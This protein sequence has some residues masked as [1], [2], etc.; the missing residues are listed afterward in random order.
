[1]SAKVSRRLVIDASVVRAA[2]GKD[3]TA[4]NRE[5][6]RFSPSRSGYLSSNGRDARYQRRVE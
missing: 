5:L 3:A 6:P 1:M 4:P 2:G